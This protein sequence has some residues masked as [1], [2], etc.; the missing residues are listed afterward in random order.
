LAEPIKSQR[1]VLAP[2]GLPANI[3]KILEDALKKTINDKEFIAWNEKAD[4]SLAPVFGSELD[5]LVKNVHDF[6]KSKE[7]I[8]RESLAETK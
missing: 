3:R 8:L 7:N 2:P 1:Y 5:Q 4:L 6:Y